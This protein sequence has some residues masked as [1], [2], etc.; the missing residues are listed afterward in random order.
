MQ[1]YRVGMASG[2][3]FAT[4]MMM[5]MIFTDASHSYI[6]LVKMP[7]RKTIRNSLLELIVSEQIHSLKD[8]N[9]N[10]IKY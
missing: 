4:D 6:W 9:E 10:E 2:R 1:V 5:M 7:R 3:R 8:S